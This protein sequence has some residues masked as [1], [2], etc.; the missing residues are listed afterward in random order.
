[1]WIRLLILGI[2]K[3][4]TYL[5]YLITKVSLD[6]KRGHTK[7]KGPGC[8]KKTAFNKKIFDRQ[9]KMH[10]ALKLGLTRLTCVYNVLL[11]ERDKETLY[12]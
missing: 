10:V 12:G 3:S 1:M 5:Q 7:K 4:N 6:L 11:V 9:L 2:S 8:G